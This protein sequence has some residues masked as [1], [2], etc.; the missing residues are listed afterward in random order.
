MQE[1]CSLSAEQKRGALQAVLESDTFARSD[2]LRGFLAYLGEK[3]I[4]GRSREISEYMIAVEALG[5]P[6]DFSPVD[7]SSVRGRAHELRR[8][9]QKYYESENPNA[10]F[11]ILL[12]KGLYEL[13]FL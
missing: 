13:R 7:D 4:A 12:P 8:K 6:A 2:Q 3:A 10:E 11:L 1:V 9:L 5:R